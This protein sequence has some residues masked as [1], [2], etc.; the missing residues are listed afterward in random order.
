MKTEVRYYNN[1]RTQDCYQCF[2]RYINYSFVV[3][4]YKWLDLS[5]HYRKY[6]DMESSPRIF[7]P[8]KR[9]K[10]G[11]QP[12][13]AINQGITGNLP[14]IFPREKNKSFQY[15]WD[16]LDDESWLWWQYYN[17]NSFEYKDVVLSLPSLQ[18]V[19]SVIFPYFSV[20][21]LLQYPR[22][23]LSPGLLATSWCRLLLPSGSRCEV[24]PEY[25]RLQLLELS[26]WTVGPGWLHSIFF[27]N[28]Q[29]ILDR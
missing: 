6:D 28:S 22:G 11:L 26:V 29:R 4:E 25:S 14:V 1:V 24:E 27:L 17:G 10:W 3:W 18:S 16:G 23:Q 12:T 2:T 13:P 20:S 8:N 9:N 7:L 21:N 15:P 5:H 19:S